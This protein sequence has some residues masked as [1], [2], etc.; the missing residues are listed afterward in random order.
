MRREVR[1]S[2]DKREPVV[3]SSNFVATQQNKSELF[4][5]FAAPKFGDY[6]NIA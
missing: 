4:F 5:A 1:R 2:F 3:I 6:K